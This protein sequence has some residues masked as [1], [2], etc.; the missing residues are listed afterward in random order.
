MSYFRSEMEAMHLA[1]SEDAVRWR[2]LDRLNPVLAPDP[3]VTSI[4]DPFIRRGLD[5]RFHMLATNGWSSTSIVHAASDDLV[6]WSAPDLIGVMSAV[7]DACNAWAPEFFVDERAGEHVV[8]WSSCT[9]AGRRHWRSVAAISSRTHNHRIW[10]CR[11]SDFKTWTAPRVWFDPGY[12]VID[13]AVARRNGRWLMAFKDERGSN[14]RHTPYK[15]I[16]L[17]GFD[18]P[19]GPFDEPTE[20]LSSRPA[21]G[22]ALIAADD[23]V[24]LLFDHF[25]HDE[26]GGLES[27]D[28]LGWR[29]LDGLSVPPGTR[30]ASILEVD[31][32][33]YR[34]LTVATGAAPIP[35]GEP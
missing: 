27:P 8:T 18:T 19:D 5:G 32:E 28:G 3:P 33:I 30:H 12:T 26:Y 7:P 16:R 2:P 29:R 21:E 34:G 15:G 11:S 6:N 20:I 31:A 14:E 13:A 9:E 24:L 1:V 23:R 10:S 17:T 4:R 22:P 35:D 25:L